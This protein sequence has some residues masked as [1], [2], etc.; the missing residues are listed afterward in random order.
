V[1]LI[2]A[3]VGTAILGTLLVG[4]LTAD[5]RQR[6]QTWRAER[7]IEA[8]AIADELLEGWWPKRD[9]L[10]RASTG[11]VDGHKGWTWRTRTVSN[12]DAERMGAEVVVLEVFGP[13]LPGAANSPAAAALSREP[14]VSVELLMP[15][16]L[17]PDDSDGRDESGGGR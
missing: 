10:P 4:I 13:Q 6:R 3:V 17:L 14:S 7:R 2:E 15:A 9:K 12:R 5:S 8:C 1:T 11:R 16:E